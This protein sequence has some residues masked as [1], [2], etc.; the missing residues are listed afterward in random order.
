MKQQETRG[1][2][3]RN[4]TLLLLGQVFSLLGNGALRFAL[5]MYVLEATGSAAVFG[6]L[7]AVSMVPTILLTPF[8]GVLADRADRRKVMVGLDLTSGTGVL[9]AAAVFADSR[10]VAVT[11]AL[12]MA[13]S[14]LGAF[15]SPTVQAC[16]PQ[17]L[18]GENI[19]KGNAAVNQAN[20]L[21]GLVTPFL[22]SLLYTAFGVRLVLAGAGACFLLTAAL[23]CFIRL[24]R[25]A[26]GPEQSLV[27]IL[28]EDL[29][30]S[31]RFLARERRE[32][33]DLLLFAAVVGALISGVAFVGLPYL[34]RTVL[35][36]SA[37][38]YGAAESAVGL[39]A[40]LGGAAAGMLA[41]PFRR[42][43]WLVTGVGACMLL[44]GAALAAPVGAL[45]QYAVLVAMFCVGQAAACTFSIFA[46]SA[47]QQKTPEHMT[48][49]VMACVSTISMCAQPLGQ[50]AYGLWFDLS[51]GWLVL[52][53]SGAAVFLL[54][55]L[56]GKLFEKW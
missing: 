11:A 25:M 15:E 48:G 24:P 5:S 3:S 41:L 10:G 29:L 44:G 52:A 45:G 43:C 28:Q 21:S 27:E 55:T 38:M 42:L 17:M 32:V 36:L 12:L 2:F 34:I 51:P 18:S 30:G 47:I 16:V 40:L 22:G 56:S 33:L 13:L 7:L 23:E 50:L 26:P 8:G 1:I 9:L 35:G 37:Q 6:T 31:A 14:V 39:A 46:V 53:V 54:G 20:A 49:K 19:L 4:F